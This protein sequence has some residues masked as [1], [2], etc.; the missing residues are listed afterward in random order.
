MPAHGPA[1][2]K[3]LRLLRLQEILSGHPQTSRQLA[4]R[5]G[6][7]VRL[8]TVQRDLEALRQIGVDL[9]NDDRG[10]YYIPPPPSE[11]NAVEA[12]A[13]HAAVRLLFHH[14]EDGNSHYRSALSKLA[15]MLPD[16]ARAVALA[17]TEELRERHA[18]G[19]ELEQVATAWF[20]RHPLS[21]AYTK[22]GGAPQAGLELEV[23]F[24]EISR[25]NLATYVIGKER[26]RRGQIRTFKLSRMHRIE[27]LRGETYAIPQ[28]FN[29]RQYLS[30]AWGVV[31]A[32][33]GRIASVRLRF[34]KAAAYRIR[35]GGYS[36]LQI[37]REFED[38]SLEV[39]IE[40][41]LDKQGFPIE[42]LSWV[43]GWGDQVDVLAPPELRGRW[44]EQARAVACRADRPPAELR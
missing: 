34:V 32:G 26:V 5:L 43:L 17:S 27:L 21:F 38:G 22:P 2:T 15:K 20:E 12:L 6:E 7:G 28:D 9:R 30:Q 8:R 44:L 37:E 41:G 35:E 19:R 4:E 10:R 1:S 31:G 29:P 40:V 16:P 42:I 11:L 23:Y 18:N 33:S 24:V 36:G 13:V 25:V 39:R 14:T 3:A